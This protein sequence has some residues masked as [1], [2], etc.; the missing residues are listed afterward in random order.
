MEDIFA[1][2]GMIAGVAP[3]NSLE[4]EDDDWGPPQAKPSVYAKANFVIRAVI[5]QAVK[6]GFESRY[7]RALKK[8]KNKEIETAG[9]YSLKVSKEY[10][11]K[12]YPIQKENVA[13]YNDFGFFLE[14][15]GRYEKAVTLLKK[16]I[17]V[18]PKRI[19]V[20]INLGDAYYGLKQPSKAKKSYQT[21]IKLMKKAGK[22]KRIPKQVYQ[23]IK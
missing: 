17:E 6:E 12:F 19:V 10:Y 7:Q 8:Y 14:Q 3:L 15:S 18:F 13:R 11:P 4:T 23:R 20:Y 21:Y 2:Q 22:T 9:R 16:V 1:V 5:K